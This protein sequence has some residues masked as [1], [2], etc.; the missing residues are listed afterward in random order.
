MLPSFSYICTFLGPLLIHCKQFLFNFTSKKYWK[1]NP[2]R[3]K[4]SFNFQHLPSRPIPSKGTLKVTVTTTGCAG[5]SH[6]VK[7]LEHVQAVIT[8]SF[9]R[10]GDLSIKLI[11]PRG[12]VA[13]LLAQR[14]Q[15]YSSSGF[16][17][18]EFMSTHTWGEDPQGTWTLEIENHGKIL[19]S[20]HV[21]GKLPPNPS[22]KPTFFHQ[23]E[24]SVNVGLGEG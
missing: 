16:T 8:L 11:S 14:R 15:D 22:P 23:W 6:H 4:I 1:C 9:S 24:V 7:Y 17:D 18:W 5:D 12:T 21:S 20:L 19:G 3:I 13:I 2:I 10:R